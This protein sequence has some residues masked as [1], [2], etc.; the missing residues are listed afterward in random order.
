MNVGYVSISKNNLLLNQQPSRS[1]F[2]AIYFDGLQHRVNE[3]AWEPP[4]QEGLHI[5]LTPDVPEQILNSLGDRESLFVSAWR[6]RLQ[7]QPKKRAGDGLDWDHPGF[8]S[9]R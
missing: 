4:K 5:F 3:L 9:P 8:K 1:S 7:Q 2:G 6:T